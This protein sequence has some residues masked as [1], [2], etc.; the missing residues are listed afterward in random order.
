MT[1]GKST[2]WLLIALVLALAGPSLAAEPSRPWLKGLAAGREEA[3]RLNRP[4]L[5][6][7]GAEWCSWCRQEDREIAKGEV[8]DE[9]RRWTLVS[10]DA[11]RDEKEVQGLGVGPIPAFRVLT[12]D[13]RVVAD[14]E[15]YLPSKELTGWLG[16]NFDKATVTALDVLTE[17]GEPSGV[18]LVRL[19]RLFDRPEAV[20]REAVVLR[21]RDHPALA[22]PA[23]AEAFSKGP[24]QARLTA[25]ELLD[26]W[27]APVEG[28]NPWRPATLTDARLKGLRDWAE[29]AAKAG[30]SPRPAVTPERL[31]MAVRQ[32]DDYLKADATSF[33]PARERLAPF[34]R[35]LMPAVLER[36]KQAESD[37]A[38][39]RLTALRYRLASGH[40]L[41][42]EW[43]GGL[44]R[45]ASRDVATRHR[46]VEELV[47]L[48]PRGEDGLWLELFSDPDPLVRETA[49][50]GLN[51]DG[52][53]G[54]SKALLGLLADPEPNVRAAVLKQLAEHPSPGLS[55]KI[56]D[57]VA[58]ETDPDLLVHAVRVLRATADETSL[59]T[60]MGLMKHA[61]WRIRAEATEAVGKR[62]ERVGQPPPEAIP[63]LLGQLDD[64]DG[65]VIGRAME[66]LR[67]LDREDMV[68]P[69][70]R[71]AEMHR[72]LAPR[73]IEILASGQAKQ[74]KAR[75]MLARFAKD[76]NPS[77]R[78]A[79]VKGLGNSSLAEIE[80]EVRAGLDDP[81]GLVRAAAANA[82]FEK[83][84]MLRQGGMISF[85]VV[86]VGLPEA[87]PRRR[88]A[89]L[90]RRFG[91]SSAEECRSRPR[92]PSRTRCRKTRPLGTKPG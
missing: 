1:P 12:P 50:R 68:N 19:V 14:R 46:A 37:E 65:F 87:P 38:R 15:G 82:L 2:G 89:S 42:I 85:H 16:S 86:P 25:L 52:P 92:S 91:R 58:R 73:V 72:D 36:L 84:S 31:A 17:T 3:T 18:A 76:P 35:A 48:G 77:V 20:T 71:V 9:L 57:Y 53:A 70:I 79:V 24:L 32:I 78:A 59:K 62:V 81:D 47:G 88:S 49:L 26:D 33:I 34:G 45:L 61:N 40:A 22:A 23:V 60:L 90:A 56:A 54:S 21:L 39:E 43:P 4:I 6:R 13:G 10:L 64:P 74:A 83:L 7:V 41:T 29:A 27:R 75:P 80:P 63:A 30:P 55:A 51:R 67:E 28:I 66:A 5:V 69:L 8:Q 11:D 44:D